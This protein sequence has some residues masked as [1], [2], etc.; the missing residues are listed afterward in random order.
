[1]SDRNPTAA[2][3]AKFCFEVL[4][5]HNINYESIDLFGAHTVNLNNFYIRKYRGIDNNASNNVI[6]YFMPFIKNKDIKPFRKTF[7]SRRLASAVKQKY[8]GE[9]LA[10]RLSR[11]TYQRL[12][13]E[14]KLEEFFISQGFEV[15][16]PEDFQ[17]LED[18]INYFY[19]VKTIVSITGGGL[20][21]MVF[22]QNGGNVIELMTT[23]ITNQSIGSKAPSGLEEGQ[24]HFYHSIAFRKNFSYFGIPNLDAKYDTLITRI[25]QDGILKMLESR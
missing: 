23:L 21:N 3:T 14:E 5:Y 2:K 15:I 19:E 12:D 6:K 24:H 22:M 4:D 1:M 18:Q 25:E 17:S 13:N 10:N 9:A 20:T 8:Y 11:K 7:V 16:C